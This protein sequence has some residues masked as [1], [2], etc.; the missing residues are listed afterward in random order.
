MRDVLVLLLL[1]FS[2]SPRLREPASDIAT[3]ELTGGWKSE[4]VEGQ[5]GRSVQSLC[6]ARDGS[7]LIQ[8]ATQAGTFTRISTYTVTDQLVTFRWA[9]GSQS[10]ASIRLRND[11]L[12]LTSE[13]SESIE[14]RPDASVCTNPR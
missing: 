8:H 14:Y 1:L 13:S 6:F 9:T 2:C 3:P 12:V 11:I 4:Q 10:T 5:F 7:I